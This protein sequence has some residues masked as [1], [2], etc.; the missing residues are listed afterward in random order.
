MF[1]VLTEFQE[2]GNQKMKICH[3]VNIETPDSRAEA[4][5]SATHTLDLASLLS[6]A[7]DL[8]EELEDLIEGFNKTHNNIVSFHIVTY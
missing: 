8:T 2:N 3:V 7:N 6:T 5:K 4:I 1:K